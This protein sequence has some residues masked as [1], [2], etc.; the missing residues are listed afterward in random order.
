MRLE[1]YH[2]NEC[3]DGITLPLKL[4]V[5]FQNSLLHYLIFAPP[6]DHLLWGLS[7][8]LLQHLLWAV[9]TH[10]VLITWSLVKHLIT[11]FEDFQHLQNDND[12][13]C[14]WLTSHKLSLNSNK[15]KSSLICRKSSNCF[16]SFMW[17][18][19]CLGLY[20][21]TDILES[22]YPLTSLGQ[23]MLKISA[24]KEESRLVY[25]TVIL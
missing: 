5:T 23:N 20:L 6:P 14:N 1:I 16:A 21:L 19:L 12:E 11:R 4:L 8:S 2:Y 7:T 9:W 10:L 18:D 22:W 3:S 15:C 13:L 24:Q 25:Y 17:M